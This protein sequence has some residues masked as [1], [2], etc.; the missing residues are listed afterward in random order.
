[1]DRQAEPVDL[2]GPEE[3][4][5]SLI[6]D[7]EDLVDWAVAAGPSKARLQRALRVEY[8]GALS[9]TAMVVAALALLLSRRHGSR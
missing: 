8:I 6:T 2:V 3:E 9:V 1:M 7:I 5:R 4:L